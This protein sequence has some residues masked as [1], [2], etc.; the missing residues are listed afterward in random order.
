MYTTY[1]YRYAVLPRGHQPGAVEGG[2]Q[3]GQLPTQIPDEGRLA[4]RQRDMQNGSYREIVDET[5]N[6]LEFSR[7]TPNFAG[8]S[9]WGRRHF[10]CPPNLKYL[11][12]PL[13]PAVV[14]AAGA[15]RSYT[16]HI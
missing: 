5:A 1:R 7:A 14:W 11:P 12:P 2:G 9:P 13:A 4:F 16:R 10:L 6:I 8:A 3:R 15:V